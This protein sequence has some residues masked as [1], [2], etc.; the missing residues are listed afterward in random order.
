MWQCMQE[1]LNLYKI[2]IKE[3]ERERPLG[4]HTYYCEVYIKLYHRTI[5]DDREH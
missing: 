5:R 4:R 3:P 1:M 2:M